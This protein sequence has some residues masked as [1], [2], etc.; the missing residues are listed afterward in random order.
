MIRAF[1][2][3][4]IF[5]VA[6]SYLELQV[7]SC[8]LVYFS[9]LPYWYYILVPRT[10]WFSIGNRAS[11]AG[12]RRRTSCFNFSWGMQ[13]A[14]PWWNLLSV[15]SVQN[16]ANLFLSSDTVPYTSIIATY[17]L[18]YYYRWFIFLLVFNYKRVSSQF[19]TIRSAGV[20]PVENAVENP[21]ICYIKY[22]VIRW[23]YRFLRK[24][25]W[26]LLFP[27]PRIP[28][29]SIKFCYKNDL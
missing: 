8:K 11:Q 26:K 19:F 5:P 3:K 28:T 21:V 7:R 20:L 25:V 13:R 2:C 4:L 10:Y 22:I 24:R 14:R 12:S 18:K 6:L 9:S 1:T 29:A 23:D 15:K 16:V 17:Q 27:A